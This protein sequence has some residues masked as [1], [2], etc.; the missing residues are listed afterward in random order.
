MT[1]F[2]G[3]SQT[4]LGEILKGKRNISP[5]NGLKLSKFFAVS[6]NYFINIQSRYDLDV[7]KEKVKGSLAE[8][9]PFKRNNFSNDELLEA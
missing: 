6:E 7:A 9:V 4:A 5:V 3:I 2:S 1:P 8:I